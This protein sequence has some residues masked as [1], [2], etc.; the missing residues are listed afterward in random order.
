[1]E[2]GLITLLMFTS[3][4]ICLA[5]GV[6]LAFGLG[7]IGVIFTYFMWGHGALVVVASKTMA[8]VNQ[9]LLI[10]LPLFIFNF[11]RFFI[12]SSKAAIS[13]GRLQLISR[14]L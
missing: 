5:I 2:G 10:A 7:A 1:M 6:P 4:L 9:D 12:L 11:I 8:T 14:N 3:V 13:F